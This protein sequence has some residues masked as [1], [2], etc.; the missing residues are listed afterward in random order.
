[1]SVLADAESAG[2][3]LT[4]VPHLGMREDKDAGADGQVHIKVYASMK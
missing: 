4:A 1:M 2:Q 3:T